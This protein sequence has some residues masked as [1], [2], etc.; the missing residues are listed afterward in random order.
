MGEP[1]LEPDCTDVVD[2]G[3]DLEETVETVEE[4]VVIPEVK[5]VIQPKPVSVLEQELVMEAEKMN[6]ENLE[7]SQVSTLLVY[8]SI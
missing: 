7:N 2:E 8:M 4:P 6:L 1:V 3:R 5:P